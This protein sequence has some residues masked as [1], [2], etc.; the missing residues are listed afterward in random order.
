MSSESTPV[1]S[2][3]VPA[4]EVFMTAWETQVTKMPR[5]ASYIKEGLE[6]AKKYYRRLDDTKAYVVSMCKSITI[7]CMVS[8]MT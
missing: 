7:C 6:L 1:L 5:L 3:T 4:F 8:Y 2:G